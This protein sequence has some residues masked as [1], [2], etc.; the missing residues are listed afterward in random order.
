MDMIKTNLS[1]LALIACIV[2]LQH[3]LSYSKMLTQ[4]IW[5]MF[6]GCFFFFFYSCP[7][8]LIVWS[9]LG[10]VFAQALVKIKWRLIEEQSYSAG[11]GQGRVYLMVQAADGLYK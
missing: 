9:P 3:L 5:S 4:T 2:I 11:A 7:A 10:H 6:R 8:P 1:A